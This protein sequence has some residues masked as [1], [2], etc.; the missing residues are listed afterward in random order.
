MIYIIIYHCTAI[1]KSKNFLF[2]WNAQERFSSLISFSFKMK[3]SCLEGKCPLLQY[4][5][6]N[7][8]FGDDAQWNFDFLCKFML[9]IFHKLLLPDKRALWWAITD[10]KCPQFWAS[11]SPLK[12]NLSVLS[13]DECFH[14]CWM[15]INSD[16]RLL[17]HQDHFYS[18]IISA[19]IICELK[20]FF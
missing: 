16:S 17:K 20:R 18:C 8:F 11:L 19:C 1:D 5:N 15:E 6:I 14:L 4:F 9:N 3:T 13:L 2:G 12:K 7:H 10:F